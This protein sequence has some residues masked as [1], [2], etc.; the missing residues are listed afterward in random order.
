MRI[1][2]TSI[3][4]LLF[5][6]PQLR[7]QSPF[8]VE[9][10]SDGFPADWSTEDI[11]GNPSSLKVL[12]NY[13]NNPDNCAPGNQGYFLNY[14]QTNF[15][16]TTAENGYMV[17][18]SA[19]VNL[20][21]NGPHVSLLTSGAIDCSLEEQV[22][23]EFETHIGF[24][25]FLPRQNAILQVSTDASSW[26]DYKIFPTVPEIEFPNNGF[27]QNPVRILLDIS[28]TA[29][30]SS[31]VYLRWHWTGKEEWNWS[32]D[33]VALYG[34][35]PDFAEVIWG[36]EPGQGDFAGGLNGWCV[37]IGNEEWVWQPNGFIGDAFSAPESFYIGSPTACNGAMVMNADFYTT[38]NEPPPP[39]NPPVYNSRLTSPTIDLSGTTEKLSLRFFQAYH[40]GNKL[41]GNPS[42][43]N[44]S[45]SLD[46]GQSWTPWVSA[47]PDRG[48]TEVWQQGWQT[49]ALPDELIGQANVRIRFIF[50]G[51]L[52]GWAIDDVQIYTR[53]RHNLEVK[54]N[55]FALSPNTLTPEDQT[56]PWH[57]LI[58]AQNVGRDTQTN[59]KLQVDVINRTTQN[60]VFS[61]VVELGTLAPDS[62][63][64]N[65]QFPNSYQAPSLPQEYRVVYSIEADS[66]D[67]FPA[68][69][70]LSYYFAITDSIFSKELGHTGAFAPGGPFAQNYSYG[71]CYFLPPVD[72]PG[73]ETTYATRFTFG[74]GN[75]TPLEGQELNI[76]L[77]QWEGDL[78]N[79]LVAN[80]NEYNLVSFNTY[81]I[82]GEESFEYITI[83]IQQ[84]GAPVP[85]EPGFY[86]FAVV[87][88]Q[89]TNNQPFFIM[90]SE[91]L[92]YQATFILYQELQK[93]RYFTM[94]ELNNTGEFSVVGL[95]ESGFGQVPVARLH[96]TKISSTE[97]LPLADDVALYPN[98]AQSS[99]RWSMPD[100]FRNAKQ[101]EYQ[102]IDAQGHIYTRAWLP[103]NT[104]EPEVATSQLPNGTYWL[105]LRQG[106]NRTVHSFHVQR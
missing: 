73:N 42:V 100:A 87:K 47:N 102:I 95:G 36:E 84:G 55:F 4:C 14:F 59:A 97:A 68:N 31:T 17:A 103:G 77:Y 85:L 8:Y 44:F 61:D 41:D 30:L 19:N 56:E 106:A 35:H 40:L 9:D 67:E 72:N 96:T 52:F 39:G 71:N 1:V 3:F 15:A 90:A 86:Y 92:D 65:V 54:R 23:L 21:A 10:F 105:H 32:I 62:L 18:N 16:S 91:A 80:Q 27:F 66:L 28:A 57:F 5:L 20:G 29:S 88:Y 51:Q 37:S 48:I 22:F 2:T 101:V 76:N 74:I 26:D 78:N 11:S 98:P 82:F 33:D 69:D 53:E 7:A 75:A 93:P 50:A 60:I 58:D 46:A 38:G 45:Y 34:Q 25:D 6:L 89:S 24:L 63:V 70:S 13:C 43:T 12:W 49:L 64:E 99:I 83:P 104:A 94:L 79:D 81:N